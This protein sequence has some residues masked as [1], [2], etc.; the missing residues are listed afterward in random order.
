MVASP[1]ASL[2][3]RPTWTIPSDNEPLAAVER[4]P[5]CTP[6]R[7]EPPCDLSSSFVTPISFN[8]TSTKSLSSSP[9]VESV[10]PNCKS[11]HCCL[12]P[13]VRQR[14]SRMDEETLNALTAKN[15][16]LL[17][18][19]SEYKSRLFAA[20]TGKEEAQQLNKKLRDCLQDATFQLS[21]YERNF[22]PRRDFMELRE[23][24]QRRGGGDYPNLRHVVVQ[25][26]PPRK[27]RHP[28]S[29]AAQAQSNKLTLQR[30]TAQTDIAV[31]NLQLRHSR[32]SC[33]RQ[34][35]S[36]RASGTTTTATRLRRVS[37]SRE[38]TCEDGQI[39]RE[40]VPGGDI[41][42][43]RVVTA[44]KGNI[45]VTVVRA[46]RMFETV[47]RTTGR[48]TETADSAAENVRA[49][50]NATHPVPG[51]HTPVLS[52]SIATS[53]GTLPLSS[54][55]SCHFHPPSN[56]LSS[57]AAPSPPTPLFTAHSTT[58]SPTVAQRPTR[59]YTLTPPPPAFPPPPPRRTTLATLS[60]AH[61]I[62]AT[63]NTGTVS[64]GQPAR[65]VVPPPTDN[66]TPL[67]PQ[68][69]SAATP[70][71]GLSAP[72]RFGY[73]TEEEPVVPL[74][75][76]GV[77]CH[78]CPTMPGCRLI[79]STYQREENGEDATPP[80]PTFLSRKSLNRPN[81]HAMVQ[82]RSY[83]QSDQP[84]SSPILLTYV[85]SA[86]LPVLTAAPSTPTL[87]AGITHAVDSG[88]T[89]NSAGIDELSD[90]DDASLA[91]SVSPASSSPVTAPS[92]PLNHQQVQPR[93]DE[94]KKVDTDMVNDSAGDDEGRE[95]LSTEKTPIDSN[96]TTDGVLAKVSPTS[97]TSVSASSFCLPSDAA[98]SPSTTGC[99]SS[100]STPASSSTPSS[101][102]SRPLQR[103]S[104]GLP[105]LPPSTLQDADAKRREKE[106]SEFYSYY[107]SSYYYYQAYYPDYNTQQPSQQRDVPTATQEAPPIHGTSRVSLPS[108]T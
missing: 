49:V 84:P 102:S 87:S 67:C 70:P 60:P 48:S 79:D 86:L 23:D 77:V 68:G 41:A 38:P 78:T 2:R 98:G 90:D 46:P 66:A 76:R 19:A 108:S 91:F 53:T 45:S 12:S 64:P 32:R 50:S 52:E 107:W 34:S 16:K 36:T 47:G 69:T 61:P 88:D 5:R 94:I 24:H 42:N 8:Q 33:R 105:P 15:Q 57:A 73:K 81:P 17:K 30:S 89:A 40:T 74:K 3:G 21:D 59:R 20:L 103:S 18:T 100:S 65:P 104:S 29:I 106:L 14:L 58:P 22:V 43:G 51:I 82:R 9:R 11:R 80:R 26:S 101:S 28:T 62:I 1:G 95:R 37:T 85:P 63:P 99:P 83:L 27:H 97:S 44:E 7:A 6:K 72:Y 92:T 13:S 93:D 96:A 25:T 31:G 54:A 71:P 56:A 39:V 10:Q 35:L 55:E 4:R 75:P